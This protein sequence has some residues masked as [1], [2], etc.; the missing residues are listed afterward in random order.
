M[1]ETEHSSDQGGSMRPVQLRTLG[2]AGLLLAATACGSGF[3][4]TTGN[5]E[6]KSGPATLNLLMA[7]GG[8]A[9][10]NAVRAAADAWAK[11]T[12]NT[13]NVNPANDINQQL[14]QGFAAGDPPDVFMV[15]ATKFAAYA[16]AGN[17][18]PYGDSLSYK[19]DLYPTLRETFTSDGKFYCAPKDFS[20]LALQIRT[21]AWQQ[22]GLTDADIPKDWDQ[23]KAVAQRLTTPDRVGLAINDSKDRVGAFV[24]QSGGWWLN[25][26]QTQAT[27]DTPE[28][29]RALQFVRDLLASGV[30]KF[31][32]QLGAGD[33]SEAFGQGK[34]AMVIDGNWM[35][36]G[37]REDYPDVKFTV[38]PLPKGP[39][40]SGTLSFTECWGIAA[41]SE[42]QEQAKSLVDA[43]MEPQ[44]QLAF[45]EAFG[46]MP[47]RQSVRAQFEARFPEQAAFLQGVENAQGPVTDAKMDPVMT[48]L[49]NKIQQL[50]GIDPA[51]VL[52]EF[53]QNASAALGG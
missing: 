47:S 32:K 53:Q 27:G 17:L 42:Y 12:G 19:D 4:D 50:P 29:L 39:K 52:K 20:T 41:K 6:Q 30:A 26:D 24:V 13:V 38:A 16:E 44:Q 46:V 23:L 22:A 35:L 15:N 10:L 1:W 28:N 45:A 49:E 18:L 25:K 3:D 40:G 31:P 51:Q 36:G 9:D 37:M 2:I 8:E 11:K 5:A 7:A 33:G 14:S 48:D 43:L 34:A 21:D